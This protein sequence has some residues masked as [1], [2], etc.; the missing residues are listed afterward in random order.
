MRPRISDEKREEIIDFVKKYP[1][2]SYQKLGEKLGV[3]TSFVL[4]VCREYS[5]DKPSVRGLTNEQK[6]KI[7]NIKEKNPRWSVR[8]IAKEIDFAKRSAIANVLK[9]SRI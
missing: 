6:E 9:E 8:R 1:T 4:L 7:I 2:L 3:S 5:L